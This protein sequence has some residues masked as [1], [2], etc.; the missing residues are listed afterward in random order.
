MDPPD[1]LGSESLLIPVS[2]PRL[3]TFTCQGV[4]SFVDGWKYFTLCRGIARFCCQI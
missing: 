4:P 2:C 1:G 3:G